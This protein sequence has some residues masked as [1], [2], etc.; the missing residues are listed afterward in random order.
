M[1]KDTIDFY[2]NIYHP[3]FMD[4]KF[5][6]SRKSWHG[7]P[8]LK[9]FEKLVNKDNLKISRVLD[10]GCAWGRTLKYW[11]KKK[12]KAVGVD[13]SMEVVD[14]CNNKGYESYMASATD[15]SIFKDKEFDLYIST[16][17]YEHLKEEDLLY[18][19][20][21]AKRV[22]NKYLLIQPS[23]GPDKTGELHLTIW[24]FDKWKVFFE[25]NNLKILFCSRK[26]KYKNSFLM[27]VRKS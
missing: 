2:N 12:I 5:N 23:T 14:Y 15:L 6:I 24:S 20:E 11:K 9:L 4:R 7:A 22:T 17:V 16:D 13:V 26:K 10:V 1:V 27:E 3:L 21:E 25:K 8:S 18:S 19:I